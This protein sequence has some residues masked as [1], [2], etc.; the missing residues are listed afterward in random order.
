MRLK[1]DG[2]SGRLKALCPL[3]REKKPSFT[4]WPDG[5]YYCYGCDAHGDVTELCALLDGISKGEA[6]RK[7]GAGE[8]LLPS[9]II[10]ALPETKP[11]PYLLSIQDRERMAKAAHRLARN[12]ILIDKLIDKRPEWTAET[13]RTVALEGD[14]G[15]EAGRIFFGYS[16]GIKARWKDAEGERVIRWLVGSAAGECWHQS[17]LIRSHRKIYITEGESDALTLISL[18]AEIPGESLVVALASAGMMPKREPFAGRDIVIVPDP[19]Q[20]GEAAENKLRALLQPVARSILTI[21][22]QK[23]LNG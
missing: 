10:K 3:H 6:A 9:T 23:V 2:A 7:L 13:I 8:D 4:I 20:A 15:Y 12:A 14:L 19:D 16:H 18:E 22:I 11:E 1:H 17:L 5:Y 21:P